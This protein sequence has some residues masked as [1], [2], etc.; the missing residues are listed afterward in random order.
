ME[1]V[2]WP[3]VRVERGI[4]TREW[5]RKGQCDQVLGYKGAL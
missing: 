2:V 1:G 4:I 3:G 5:G